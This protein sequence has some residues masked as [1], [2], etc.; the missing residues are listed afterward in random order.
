MHKHNFLGNQCQTIQEFTVNVVER[1]G[2]LV[3]VLEQAAMLVLQVLAQ[4]HSLMQEL[5][6]LLKVCLLQTPRGHGRRPN[7][8]PP[9]I[10]SC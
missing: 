8:P 2:L 9:C 6:N 1:A 7:T 5:S 4:L 3:E 10:I